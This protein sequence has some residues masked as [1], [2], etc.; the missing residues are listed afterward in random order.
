MLPKAISQ[1]FEELHGFNLE[2]KLITPKFITQSYF[3]T[4]A[5]FIDF[6]KRPY[7]SCLKSYRAVKI[8]TSK[9][10][11]T[12]VIKWIITENAYASN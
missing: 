9:M 4:I 7:L 5:T 6:V 2:F 11:T 1:L 8:F 3:R 10:P 12:F